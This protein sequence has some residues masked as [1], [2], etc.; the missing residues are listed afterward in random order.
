[1][2]NGTLVK[3]GD[4]Q[5]KFDK[6]TGAMTI[7][8]HGK[9]VATATG[10]LETRT[11]KARQTAVK[12]SGNEL[13]AISIGGSNQDIVLGGGSGSVSGSINF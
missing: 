5:L 12:T 4:Y 13:V 8:R 1:M 3:A 9:V 11:N 6:E 10:R 2:V 7:D